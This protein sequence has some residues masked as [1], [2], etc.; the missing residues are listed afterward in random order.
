MF[1]TW[2]G[3][4]LQPNVD[5]IRLRISAVNKRREDAADG[6]VR[7]AL[8]GFARRKAPGAFSRRE[9]V[10]QYLIVVDATTTPVCSIFHRSTESVS[11]FT[12]F[13]V[14]TMPR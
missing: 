7:V 10:V 5:A 1:H 6:P 14:Q 3:N 12:H 13:G 8:N 9:F 11:P 2:S 4:V